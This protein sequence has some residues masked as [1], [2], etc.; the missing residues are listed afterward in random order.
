MVNG[1]GIGNM[2]ERNRAVMLNK[3]SKAGFVLNDL[4]LFLDTHPTDANALRYYGYYQKRHEDLTREY[5]SRYGQ[6][7]RKMGSGPDC[8]NRW[9]WTDGPW[10]WENEH[11]MEV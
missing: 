10:P 11:N 7:T 5:E 6:L 9:T 4:A 1:M 3:I 8:L 2:A